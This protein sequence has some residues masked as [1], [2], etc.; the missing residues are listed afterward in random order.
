MLSNNYLGG[1]KKMITRK[2]LLSLGVISLLAMSC[3]T[4]CSKNEEALAEAYAAGMVDIVKIQHLPVEPLDQESVAHNLGIKV[5]ERKDELND[6]TETVAAGATAETPASVEIVYVID[7]LNNRVH[8]HNSGCTLLGEEAGRAIIE[9]WTDTVDA[10]VAAGYTKCPE[11]ILKL[12][13]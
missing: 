5:E 4:G 12:G 9:N 10:A 6:G 8:K 13:K 1:A 3:V 11:C 7:T 2:K